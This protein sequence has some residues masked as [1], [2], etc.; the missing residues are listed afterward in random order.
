MH[1]KEKF[2]AVIQAYENLGSK[3]GWTISERKSIPYGVQL[4]IEG[5]ARTGSGRKRDTATVNIYHGKKGVRVVIGGS[6]KS[7]LVRALRRF[8][9]ERQMG[10]VVL[11]AEN[12][13][14]AGSVR[15]AGRPRIGTDEAGKGD[16]FGPLVVAAVYVDGGTEA[17][18]L[19]LG[20]RDSKRIGD[21]QVARM[22]RQIKERVPSA[23]VT[24]LPKE[25]NR[26]YD[27]VRNLNKLLAWAHAEAIQRLLA[28]VDC[29]LVLTDRFGN[30][31]HLIQALG[32]FSLEI[33]LHQ[34][35]RAEADAAVAAASVLAR[36]EYLRV[37]KKLSDK[38]GVELPKGATHV[39][40]A[41]R[42]L[43]ERHGPEAL[44][45]VAKWHFKTTRQI[46]SGR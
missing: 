3:R 10:S 39:V 16:Y 29:S 41:G 27:D 20:L 32:K 2:D 36:A 17:G 44:R 22:A 9:S 7:E 14:S 43:V 24:L 25:Y 23:V 18:L 46:L 13:A 42:R 8:E 5:E 37:L 11:T 31:R 15:F 33:E 6:A 26:R 1:E 45:R 28:K 38:A 21:V 12:P 19:D 35:E 30:P 4:R 34:F 40:E